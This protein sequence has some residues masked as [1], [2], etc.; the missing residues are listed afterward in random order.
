MHAL[1]LQMINKE[2]EA[3]SAGHSCTSGATSAYAQSL[4]N[5]K[6]ICDRWPV[7][8]PKCHASAKLC[9]ADIQKSIA[10]KPRSAICRNACLPSLLPNL[11]CC[12]LKF[13]SILS[14]EEVE[15]LTLSSVFLKTMSFKSFIFC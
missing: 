2:S 4:P 13:I 5:F 9:V 15:N 1:V 11:S 8:K 12:N 3:T 14:R 7:N 6:L 10:K